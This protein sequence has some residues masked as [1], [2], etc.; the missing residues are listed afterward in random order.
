MAFRTSVGF[1]K[2][3]TWILLIYALGFAYASYA[4]LNATVLENEVDADRAMKESTRI[5][6]E[7]RD[8]NANSRPKNTNAVKEM[9]TINVTF[10]TTEG[11]F[12]L[13]LF[14]EKAP[15]TVSNFLKLA[16]EGFYNGTKFHRVIDA[17]MI[18]GGDPITKDDTRQ[19][20]WGTGGPGYT[21]EDEFAPGLTNE[22]GT[23]SMANRGPNTNG[24]QFFINVANNSFLDGKHAVFGK[25]VSG[26]NVVDKISQVS[27]D[28]A[29][30]P[31]NPIVI[32]QLVI[33]NK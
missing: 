25:V 14:S 21:F 27:T 9:E 15:K 31:I 30:R 3:V 7:L 22:I 18:Q 1:Q 4:L 17:F 2:V 13:E 5:Y 10:Q 8:K 29:D 11:D 12:A 19:S 26:M 33:E 6:Q 23:I 32:K 16:N 24:S 20:A 28:G